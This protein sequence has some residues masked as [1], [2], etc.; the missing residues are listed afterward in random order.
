M[1]TSG[2]WWKK[3]LIVGLGGVLLLVAAL[4]VYELKRVPPREQR[5]EGA[6]TSPLTDLAGKPRRPQL[7]SWARSGG[8]KAPPPKVVVKPGQKIAPPAPYILPKDMRD[9]PAPAPTTPEPPPIPPDP[10]VPPKI[11]QDPHR[12]GRTR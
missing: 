10:S 2:G 4:L 11:V 5:G 8:T 1:T 12:G 3:G 6:E 7:P 9:K